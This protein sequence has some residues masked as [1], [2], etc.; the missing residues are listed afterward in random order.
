M[1]YAGLW[2]ESIYVCLRYIIFMSG[3]VPKIAFTGTIDL[4]RIVRLAALQSKLWK[5]IELREGKEIM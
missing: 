2:N 1:E 4:N 5:I 3:G